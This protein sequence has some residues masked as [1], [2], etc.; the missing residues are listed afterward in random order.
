MA[1]TKVDRA[2]I[3]WKSRSAH[4]VSKQRTII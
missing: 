4:V 1:Q 2:T 3:C